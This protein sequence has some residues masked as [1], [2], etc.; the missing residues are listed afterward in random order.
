M[1]QEYKCHEITAQTK[2]PR[3]DEALA[4]LGKI[5]A[6]VQPIMFK[7]KWRVQKLVE[8]MPK[9]A[10]L[11]GM[12]MNKGQKIS[13]RLRPHSDPESFYPYESLL[14]TMLHELTHMQIGAHSAAFYKLLDK[15]T[16]E[17]EGY[18][19]KGITGTAG[20]AFADAGAHKFNM[21]SIIFSGVDRQRQIAWRRFHHV[22]ERKREEFP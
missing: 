19:A 13:I 22:S 16:E 5:A 6:Q 18:A 2:R 7:H 21:L 10:E 1:A 17:C 11:L 12:N 3:C 4:I 15:L 8:F 20:I 9:N 14:G